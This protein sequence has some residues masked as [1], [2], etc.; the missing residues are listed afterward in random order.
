MAA[1]VPD[2]V[3]LTGLRFSAIHGVHE[4]ERT[5]PQTFVVDVTCELM[6]R[7]Q[8]DELASTVDYAELSREIEAAVTRDPVNLI[9]TLAERIAATCLHHSL[10]G[11]V[12]VT[13]HKP[14]A[15]MPVQLSD[16]AVTIRRSRPE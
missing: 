8:S 4:F 7:Q 16:V 1:I 10:V 5:R 9:E 6:P 15:P 14:D 2:R 3:R 12:E 13:V 11:A